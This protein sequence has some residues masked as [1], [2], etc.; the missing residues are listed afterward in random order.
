MIIRKPTLLK[1]TLAVALSAFLFG[2]ASKINQANYDKI[3]NGMTMEQVEAILG[4]ATE[5]KTAGIGPLSGT[6]AAWSSDTVTISIKFVNGKV[7]LK[8]FTENK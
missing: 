2:C 7:Q 6:S 3:E 4:K 8:S 5:A 1:L